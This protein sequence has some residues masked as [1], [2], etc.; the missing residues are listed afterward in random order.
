MKII[1]ILKIIAVVFLVIVILLISTYF[2]ML[3][4]GKKSLMDNKTE[5]PVLTPPTTSSDQEEPLPEDSGDEEYSVKYNGKKY[6][7]NDSIVNLLFIG[8][9]N[10]AEVEKNGFYTDG[11][12]ADVLL[13]GCM[14]TLNKTI[15][16]ISIPRDTITEIELFDYY[17]NSA[18]TS[19]VQIALSYAFGDGGETSCEITSNA[20]SNLLYGLP[21][22]AWY[23]LD[24]SAVAAINDAVG[25]VEVTV[26]EK[27]KPYLPSEAK[28]GEK[29]LLKGNFAKRFISLR[30]TGNDSSRR[31]QQKEY[32]KGFLSSAKKSLA[33]NPLLAR[34]I[35]QN[36]TDYSVTNLSLDE[37]LYL[38]D[39]ALKMEIDTDFVTLN[40]EEIVV[41]NKVEIHLDEKALYEMML[42]IFYVE[43]E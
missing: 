41:D 32:L 23:S 39:E 42:D 13:L 27:N 21:I 20:V 31:S 4:S 18:G 43:V 7:Y 30:G 35:I 3:N 17:G 12:Q 9:D 8:V 1:K 40:G 16:L 5:T 15:K 36:V 24:V 19:D 38:I 2:I 28:I 22:H 37:M 10:K 29:Y 33:K 6:I 11:G 34:R 14:D 26:T 25:G